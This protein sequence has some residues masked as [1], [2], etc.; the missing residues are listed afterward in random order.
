VGGGSS[1]L[2]VGD[3]VG[4]VRWWTSVPTGSG[5]LTAAFVRHDPPEAAEIE[6]MRAHVRRRFDGLDPPR[7][8]LAVAVG[9][10]ATSLLHMTGR[11]LDAPALDRALELLCSHPAARVAADTALDAQRVKLLP[12]GLLILREAARRFDQPLV[13]GAAGL[14]EGV[15]LRATIA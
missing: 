15:L 1:E 4:T 6:T 12:A 11:V 9:G 5:E 3:P 14:R 7:P 2:V 10:S 13:V 8:S